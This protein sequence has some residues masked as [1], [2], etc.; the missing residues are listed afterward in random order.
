MCPTGIYTKIVMGPSDGLKGKCELT[1]R[2]D[3]SSLD[4]LNVSNC[5]VGVGLPKSGA[6]HLVGHTLWG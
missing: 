5:A 3:A 2:G 6:L 1:M 4:G